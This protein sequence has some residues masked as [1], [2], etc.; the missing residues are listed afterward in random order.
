MLCPPTLIACWPNPDLLSGRVLAV[1]RVDAARSDEQVVD[2]ALALADRDRV[3]TCQ[4]R[5]SSCRARQRPPRPWPRH[6]RRAHGS[7]VNGPQQ[8][9]PNP[10]ALLHGGRLLLGLRP[11]L[12][13]RPLQR[14][15]VARRPWSLDGVRRLSTGRRNA[16][17]RELH[18]RRRVANGCSATSKGPPAPAVRGA[19]RRPAGR[20]SRPADRPPSTRRRGPCRSGASA[21]SAGRSRCAS[22]ERRAAGAAVQDSCPG[23][24]SLL[25][26]AQEGASTLVQVCGRLTVSGRSSCRGAVG[27]WRCRVLRRRAACIEAAG[28]RGTSGQG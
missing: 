26:S 15:A 8:E 17:R 9:G 10:R 11:D 24:D 6:G 16:L 20:A 1:D 2:V 28:G 14:Q 13:P 4:P 22:S 27:R 12:L 25:E 19:A 5:Y 23:A 7:G 21:W 18:L 3:R